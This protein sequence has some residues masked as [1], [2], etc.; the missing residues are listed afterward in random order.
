V[1]AVDRVDA[2]SSPDWMDTGLL[3]MLSSRAT[4]VTLGEGQ[5]Q[6]VSLRVMNQ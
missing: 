5:S 2:S 1:V 4:R 3:T 6:T